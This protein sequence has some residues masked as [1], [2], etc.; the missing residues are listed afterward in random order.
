MLSY[1]KNQIEK[2]G[3]RIVLKQNWSKMLNTISKPST[4]TRQNILFMRSGRQIRLNYH[5]N[6]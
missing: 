6:Q 1:L 5:M 3:Y 4:L 2:K